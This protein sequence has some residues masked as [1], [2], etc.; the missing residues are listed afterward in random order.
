MEYSNDLCLAWVCG[1]PQI[2][3]DGLVI[4]EELLGLVVRDS[5]IDNDV[6]ARFPVDGGGDLVFVAKLQGIYSAK[7]FI[8]VS[9]NSS[10]IGNR[11]ADGLLGVDDEDGSDSKRH[12]LAINVGSILFV[13]HIELESDLT[14]WIGNDRI[15]DFCIS[16]TADILEPVHMGL[17]A[18]G[19]QSDDLD[20]ALREILGPDGNFAQL[21]GA[22]GCEIRGMREKEGPAVPDPFVELDGT[23]CGFRVEVWDDGSESD[24]HFSMVRVVRG[25][26]D[27]GGWDLPRSAWT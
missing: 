13:Q 24:R 12:A 17:E 21:S 7:N 20:A 22:N 5:V 4:R 19:G 8:K 6:F 23:L 9:A 18:V 3:Q 14:G 27:C 10:G 15:C 1:R 25:R 11:E 26:V 16:K 2:R